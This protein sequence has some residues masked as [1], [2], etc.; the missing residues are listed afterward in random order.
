MSNIEPTY[1]YPLSV[2]QK[3]KKDLADAEGIAQALERLNIDLQA[4]LDTERGRVAMLREAIETQAKAWHQLNI[5]INEADYSKESI[6]D[7]VKTFADVARRMYT[8]LLTQSASDWLE[9]QKAAAVAEATQWQPIETLEPSREVVIAFGYEAGETTGIQETPTIQF[10]SFNYG[11]TDYEGFNWRVYGGERYAVW[12]KP[13]LWMKA[14]QP[15]K[16]E[17]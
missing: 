1:E 13:L 5:Q 14:P 6:L 8:D 17:P 11:H 15:P 4:Q 16:E 2:V 12:F 9:Q 10:I 7:G 3:W